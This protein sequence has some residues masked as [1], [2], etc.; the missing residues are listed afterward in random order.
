MGCCR[1]IATIF[2]GGGLVESGATEAN[3]IPIWGV[4]SDP[5]IASV[6]ALNFPKTNLIIEDVCR[7]NFASLPVPDIFH[8]SPPCTN[9][10][11]AN[12]SKGEKK[13]DFEYAIAS[14]KAITFLKP[15]I[16]TLENVSS[17]L[18]SDSFRYILKALFNQQYLVTFEIINFAEYGIPQT[19]RRLFVRAFKDSGHLLYLPSK[20]SQKGW[21]NAISDL[22][23]TFKP[24]NLTKTQ[25]S[26]L[27]K[28][29]ISNHS[30]ILVKRNQI[31]DNLE[32]PIE[33][34]PAFTITAGLC[35]DGKNGNRQNFVNVID[36]NKAVYSI[37]IKALSR[38]QTVP[39]WYQFSG[40]NGLD[41]KI[42][43]N[44]VPCEFIK[45]LFN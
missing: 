1:T 15:K 10:S 25:L 23:P 22:F 30:R 18:K 26:R 4:E 33:T 34:A 41:G 27:A 24:T 42:I 8:L 35:G 17:Y 19:R 20:K 14:V 38:L 11:K 44:G 39:D 29:K 7:V 13:T 21:W 28:K 3:L 2:S 32:T 31:R 40:K 16:I 12:P 43:G 9:F 6:H 36:T 37:T 45:Q 5:E